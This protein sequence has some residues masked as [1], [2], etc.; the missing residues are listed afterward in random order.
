MKSGNIELKWFVDF[1]DVLY[2]NNYFT[3][4]SNCVYRRDAFRL[5]QDKKLFLSP[6]IQG[7]FH[8][9]SELIFVI[10]FLSVIDIFY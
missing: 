7:S 2:N 6:F 10:I 9:K 3:T 4:L 8:N 5:K 1:L